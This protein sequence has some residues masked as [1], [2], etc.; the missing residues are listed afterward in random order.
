MS[1]TCEKCGKYV[2]DI[3]KYGSGR[4][5]SRAC[6]NTRKH[7]DETKD[8]IR[9]GLAKKTTCFCTYCNKKFSALNARASHENLCKEN[10]NRLINPS[11]QHRD[12]LQRHVVLYK[13]VEG[14]NTKIELDITNEELER[15]RQSHTV[16]EICGRTAEEAT[17]WDGKF[18]AKKLCIDHDHSNNT[19]RGLLCQLCNRQLGWYEKYQNSINE[20][21]NK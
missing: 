14:L 9:L 16:C 15:Y 21:L 5:C 13:Y 8:K 17:K 10:P 3:N 1:Y 6:A 20:Y 4:F 18:A 7:S 12:K 19:F 11:T 2:E